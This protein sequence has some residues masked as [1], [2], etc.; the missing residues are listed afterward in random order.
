MM[1]GPFIKVRFSSK[2]YGETAGLILPS[3]LVKNGRI[4]I[5]AASRYFPTS[6]FRRMER[7]EFSPVFE[8]WED[9]FNFTFKES[10]K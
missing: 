5:N 8:K 3:G 1:T 10:L 6:E 9:A 2:H 4:D 7:I